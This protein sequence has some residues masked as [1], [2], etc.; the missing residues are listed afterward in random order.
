MSDIE[1]L[2]KVDRFLAWGKSEDERI[3]G[4]LAAVRQKYDPKQG[5]ARQI[6]LAFQSGDK[7]AVEKLMVD[8][9]WE[10]HEQKIE[11]DTTPIVPAK[12]RMSKNGGLEINHRVEFDSK[13]AKVDTWYD[14]NSRS[15]VTQTL[16]AAGDQIGDSSYAGTKEGSKHDHDYHLRQAGLHPEMIKA[17]QNAVEVPSVRG[18]NHPTGALS[19]AERVLQVAHTMHGKS[20][21]AIAKAVA[22]RHHDISVA[23][24]SYYLRKSGSK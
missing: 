7:S 6:Q 19:K 11:L 15:W 4:D 16:N 24:A 8:N 21:H 14:R 12:F 18:L 5:V 10:G 2:R 9:H 1:W 22:E 23:N 13:P 20:T 17:Q 3:K